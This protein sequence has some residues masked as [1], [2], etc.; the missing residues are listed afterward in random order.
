M[1]MLTT[2]AVAPA[3]A[4]SAH[5]G[6]GRP[7]GRCSPRGPAPSD[8]RASHASMASASMAIG[9]IGARS[10]RRGARSSTSSRR[11]AALLAAIEVAAHA[12]GVALGERACHVGAQPDG[13][14]VAAGVHRGQHRCD[15]ELLAEPAQGPGREVSGALLGDA[16]HDGGGGE[17]EALDDAE[18]Q[19]APPPLGQAIERL[20]GAAR[21]RSWRAGRGRSATRARWTGR[22]PTRGVVR[23]IW[24][25][26]GAN[27]WAPRRSDCPSTRAKASITASSATARSRP[28]TSA[29]RQD[30]VA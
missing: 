8:V 22:S 19:H 14:V 26:T 18:P 24:V 2:A 25:A 23:R 7:P 1:P 17:V 15:G 11:G 28:T 12:G 16:E 4:R 21:G 10:L 20:H 30:I 13:G 3:R 6:A 27:R 5:A 29:R 9:S